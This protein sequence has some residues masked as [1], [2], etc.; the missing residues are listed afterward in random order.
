VVLYI[1]ATKIYEAAKNFQKNII[2]VHF[3]KLE[4][5]ASILYTSTDDQPL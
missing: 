5:K 2:S 1:N 3:S 4:E